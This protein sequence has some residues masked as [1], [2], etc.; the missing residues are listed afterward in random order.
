MTSESTGLLAAKSNKNSNP[1]IISQQMNERS[2]SPIKVI[3]EPANISKQ[4]AMKVCGNVPSLLTSTPT[5][6]SKNQSGRF[7]IDNLLLKVNKEGKSTTDSGLF[8]PEERKDQQDSVAS[9]FHATSK[10]I[11]MHSR[12][13]LMEN[14]DFD[15]DDSYG[16]YSSCLFLLVSCSK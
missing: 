11:R 1:E 14:M 4:P 9:G 7:S 3:L 6:V 10:N 16:T 15:S 2:I 13:E 8:A 5:T 12:P